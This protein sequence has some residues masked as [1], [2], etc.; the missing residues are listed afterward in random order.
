MQKSYASK[1]LWFGE[2]CVLKGSN[3]LAVPFNRFYGKWALNNKVNSPKPDLQPFVQYLDQAAT[4]DNFPSLNIEQFKLD[5]AKGLYFKSNIPEGYGLGSSGALCAGVFDRYGADQEQSSL[6][7]LKK[8]LGAIE[9]FFHGA[10]SGTDPL[11]SY[12][13]KPILIKANGEIQI[14]R[15]PETSLP[16]GFT[17]FLL[18]TGIKRQTT[19]YVRQFLGQYQQAS[20]KQ[21]V[22]TRL[23]P[24]TNLVIE[25]FLSGQWVDLWSHWSDLSILQY[26]KMSDWIPVAFH[27]IWKS[28]LEGAL[29]KL[30]LCGAG[31]GGF[32]LGITKDWP[33][34]LET[35]GTTFSL[36]PIPTIKS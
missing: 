36:I 17:F 24:T 8:H 20:F 11:V 28:G 1:I 23:V 18:D 2:Q 16:E 12:L 30:K 29:F 7:G 34:F 25:D 32:L 3:A 31:G 5:L 21:F 26:E 4:N 14:V 15:L 22:D 9:S 6:P 35:H 33:H 27:P 13:G 10:S 19:P